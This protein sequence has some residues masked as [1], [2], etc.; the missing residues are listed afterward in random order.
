MNRDQATLNSIR[1][2]VV[3]DH[4]VVRSGLA[5]FLFSCE[6]LTPVG[7]A[8]DGAE[9]IRVCIQVKPDVVLMDLVMPVMDGVAATQAIRQSNP[10]TQVIALTSFGDE[11]LVRRAMQAG[12]ISYLLKN[13]TAEE[14]ANAIRAAHAGRPTLAPEAT[15]SL[16]EAAARPPAPVPQLTDR[17]YDVLELMVQGFSNPEIAQRLAV[18]RATVKY[19]VSNILSKLDVSNR[20][21]AISLALRR[22]LVRTRK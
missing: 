4:D 1:V 11:Q 16:M 12:A 21:E 13:V 22:N 19:H 17:E 6:D 20:A 5:A 14:L 9:A 10:E 3:D 7:E 8:A 18:T 2:V 15:K